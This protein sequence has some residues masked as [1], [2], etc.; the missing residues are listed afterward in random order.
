MDCS[1]PGFSILGILQAR[2]PEWVAM[3]S[4]RGSSWLNL[5][6]TGIELGS[7]T[8]QAD[9]LPS[10]PPGID[11]HPNPASA[12][13]E[14]KHFFSLWDAIFQ[15]KYSPWARQ[16][17]S[18]HWTGLGKAGI[19]LQ[20]SIS[21][22]WLLISYTIMLMV[23]WTTKKSVSSVTGT[24]P[25]QNLNRHFTLVRVT[26]SLSSLYNLKVLNIY[27]KPNT[28]KALL[29]ILIIYPYSHSDEGLL[30]PHFLDEKTEDYNFTPL[31]EADQR[32]H[33]QQELHYELF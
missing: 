6:W 21:P 32:S 19:C 5:D 27:W 29:K 30:S 11:N 18:R 25:L 23:Y 2:I 16:I 20:G 15:R 26:N 7:L 4:S 1:S 14:K 8:L 17:L 28:D 3:L 24:W 9:Y 22:R 33:Y 13:S 10:E 12:C 31:R